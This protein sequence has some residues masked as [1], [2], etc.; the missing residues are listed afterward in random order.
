MRK[1]SSAL[2][3]RAFPATVGWLFAD[4]LLALGM[5]FLISSPPRPKLPP[6]LMTNPAIL[7]PGDGHCTGGMSHPQCTVAIEETANS[8]QTMNW[9]VSSDMSKTVA[10][11]PA[12]G[13]LSPGKSILVTI[14]AFPCQNGS[15]TFFGSGGAIPVSVLWQCTLPPPPSNERILEHNYCQILLNIGSPLTFINESSTTARHTIETQLDLVRFLKRRQVGIAI[16]YG[17][18]IGGTE[19]QGS[20]IANQVYNV[21]QLLANDPGA[22]MYP[23]FRSSS[24]YESLFTGFQKSTIAVLNIYLVVRSDNANDTCNAQH[25]I[26]ALGIF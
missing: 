10:F 19:E 20:E 11:H 15:F 1:K 25:N 26:L 16:A 23:V 8:Q 5:V 14:S 21:L 6:T 7:H 2:N 4:L 22:Q 17:G 9:S 13:M 3:R 18:T 24:W 12:S